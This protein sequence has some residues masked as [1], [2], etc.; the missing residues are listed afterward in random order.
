MD[1]PLIIAID[2]TSSCG[3]S[4]FAKAIARWLHYIHID[5]GAMYRA[6]TLFALQNGLFENGRLDE[7]KLISLLPSITIAFK[8]NPDTGETETWLNGKNVEKEIRSIEVSGKVSEVS[9]IPQVREHLVALQR[10]MAGRGGVVMDGRDIGTV[11]FPQ[12][13]IKIFM[14]ATPEVRA[15]RR[16]KEMLEKKEHATFEEV[17]QNVKERDRIDSGREV[18]PLRKA[19]D[20][21]VLDNSGMTVEEQMAWVKEIIRKK[22]KEKNES[23]DAD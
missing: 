4:T 3:K 7:K 18:S 21:L 11:V 19:E 2:G 9:R 6:V 17:L 16:Y 10:K 15:M 20:A 1:R 13:D 23:E 22:M 14:T 8:K 12:A 5:S